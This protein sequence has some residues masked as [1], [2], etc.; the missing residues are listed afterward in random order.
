[1]ACQKGIIRAKISL[2]IL[3]FEPD[4]S[5]SERNYACSMDFGQFPAPSFEGTVCGVVPFYSNIIVKAQIK[6][7]P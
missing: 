5:F 6:K 3:P 7:V 4:L 2:G 1:M